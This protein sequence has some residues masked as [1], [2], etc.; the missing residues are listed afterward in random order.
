MPELNPTNPKYRLFI[1]LWK[2]MPLKLS[3]LLGPLIVKN[4]G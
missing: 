4:L 1:D 2:R 3:M